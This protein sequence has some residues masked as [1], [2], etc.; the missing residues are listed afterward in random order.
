MSCPHYVW[1]SKTYLVTTELVTKINLVAIW[2]MIEFSIFF[3]IELSNW[4]LSVAHFQLPQLVT[5]IFGLLKKY[6]GNPLKIFSCLIHNG[7]S[8][9]DWII[10][11][12]Y[13]KKIIEC[14]NVFGQCPKNLVT[15]LGD[16]KFVVAN[17]GDW[18]LSVIRLGD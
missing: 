18:K 10:F 16:Q 8:S 9:N 3:I 17:L 5:K 7:H 11:R 14:L 1:Q 4:K 2:L 13:P 15:N 6:I 12:C